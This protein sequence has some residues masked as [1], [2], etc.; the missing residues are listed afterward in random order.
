MHAY[1]VPPIS[2]I[3]LG[4]QLERCQSTLLLMPMQPDRCGSYNRHIPL[5]RPIIMKTDPLFSLPSLSPAVEYMM[6]HNDQHIT[7]MPLAILVA[8][9]DVGHASLPIPALDG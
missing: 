1:Q 4:N 9:A 8:S 7:C 2:D 3:D 5:S 6:T